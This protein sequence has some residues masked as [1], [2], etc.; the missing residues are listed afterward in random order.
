M[1]EEKENDS[2]GEWGGEG[3]KS[4]FSI[5]RL[6]RL[7]WTPT[8]SIPRRDQTGIRLGPPVVC[9]Q[10]HIQRDTRA[11]QNYPACVCVCCV[12]VMCVC[13]VCVCVC[14]CVMCVCV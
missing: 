11:I 3:K 12:C 1:K 8:L 14:V 9:S 10:P 2:Q 4:Q 6:D 7:A 5:Y 13:D